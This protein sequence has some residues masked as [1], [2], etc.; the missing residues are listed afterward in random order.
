MTTVTASGSVEERLDLV[1]AQLAEISDELRR[2]RLERERWSELADDIAPLATQAMTMVASRLEADPVEPSEV[3]NLAQAVVRDAAVLESWLGPL[4]VASALAD[5]VGPL[6][7]PAMDSLTKRLQQLDERGYF[8]FVRQVVAIADTVVT[9][10]TEDDV[11]QLGDNI[12]LILQT[13]RQMTQP[14]IM[15]MLRRTV[16]TITQG[17]NGGAAAT[18][19]ST[20]ALLRELRDPQVRRGLARAIGTLRALGTD[21][22]E[23]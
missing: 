2:Q 22:Q 21:D 14:E 16:F 15:N 19:P 7:G 1:A 18:P 9:S 5:E 23:R 10:F 6:S 8:T 11:R 13:V 3:M 20:L 4:R 12:V 17:E